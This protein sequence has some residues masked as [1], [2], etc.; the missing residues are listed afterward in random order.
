[1]DEHWK[2]PFNGVMVMVIISFEKA[3]SAGHIY[4]KKGS[5]R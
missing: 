5:A 4:F 3:F 2:S 1:L